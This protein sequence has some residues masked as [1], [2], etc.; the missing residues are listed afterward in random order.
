M[1]EWGQTKDKQSVLSIIEGNGEDGGARK[2][3]K[4][5]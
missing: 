1:T 4:H 5:R 2:I 3:E